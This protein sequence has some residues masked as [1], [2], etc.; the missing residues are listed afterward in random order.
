MN[1]RNAEIVR[2][3]P[4]RFVPEDGLWRGDDEVP[5]PPRALSVLATLVARA[6]VVTSKQELMDA[7]WPDTFV[8]ESSLLEAVGLLRDALGDDRRQ[9][10]SHPDGPA[11][12]AIASS[13]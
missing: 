6:G 8:T 10:L 11:V 1:G 7:V 3:G 4:F 9:P 2:F 5:L 13:Q 12:V